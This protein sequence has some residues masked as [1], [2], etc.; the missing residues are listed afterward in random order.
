MSGRNGRAR[1]VMW[2]NNEIMAHKKNVGEEARLMGDLDVIHRRMVLSTS[3]L[4]L[5]LKK[6][7]VDL[8]EVR[9]S[10]GKITVI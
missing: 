1:S 8:K 3:G 5:E 9:R 10:T 2:S 6:L 7:H 4:S